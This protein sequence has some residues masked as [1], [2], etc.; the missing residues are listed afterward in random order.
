MNFLQNFLQ[1]ITLLIFGDNKM[2]VM[3]FFLIGQASDSL[4][5][6]KLDLGCY[7]SQNRLTHI[8]HYF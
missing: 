7:Y 1:M 6:Y 4:D 2:L 3:N 8:F 5:E